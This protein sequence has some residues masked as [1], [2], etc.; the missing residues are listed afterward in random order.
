MINDPPKKSGFQ[1]KYGFDAFNSLPTI[2]TNPDPVQTGVLGSE[3]VGESEEDK[4]FWRDWNIKNPGEQ[5][6]LAWEAGTKELKG[7]VKNMIADVAPL[8]M[9]AASPGTIPEIYQYED[10]ILGLQESAAKDFETAPEGAGLLYETVRMMPQ[11]VGTMAALT[12]TPFTGGT[13]MAALPGILGMAN[14]GMLS[15]SVYGR[16]LYDYDQY[17]AEKGLETNQFT[18][19][20][21][22]A[23]S[24]AME[25]IAEKLRLDFMLPKGMA[26]RMASQLFKSDPSLADDVMRKWAKNDPKVYQ[27]FMGLGKTTLANMGQ[28]GAEE[29]LTEVGQSIAQNVYLLGEDRLGAMDIVI[30]AGEAAKGG[31]MMGGMLGPASYSS[32]QLYHKMRKN[33][34]GATIIE[35]EDGSV[36]EYL[37]VD[38]KDPNMAT[39]MDNRLNMTSI[40]KDHI[41]DHRTMTDQELSEYLNVYKDSQE[42]LPQLEDQMRR[43]T[44][45]QHLNSVGQSIVNTEDGTPQVKVGKK[46][47]GGYV[48]IKSQW[49]EMPGQTKM[50]VVDPETMELDMMDASQIGEIRTQSYDSWLEVQTDQ[51]VGVQDQQRSAQMEQAVV[52]EQIK[53]EAGIPEFKEGEK[54][55]YQD[56]EWIVDEVDTDGT[57]NV[58]ANEED[59]TPGETIP[60]SP[61]M[62][63]EVNRYTPEAPI[64]ETGEQQG[65]QK[66]KI[67]ND[68]KNDYPVVD[69]KIQ[70]PF[71]TEKA[72]NSLVSKLKNEYPGLNFT[73]DIMDDGDPFTKNEYTITV[74]PINITNG[75]ETTPETSQGVAPSQT[76][77][78]ELKTTEPRYFKD[79]EDVTKGYIQGRILAAKSDGDLHGLSWE[80]DPELDAMRKEKFPEAVPTYT[81][82]GQEIEQDVARGI[83]DGAT[84][85]TDL[86]QLVVKNDDAT[87]QTYLDKISE[88]QPETEE[89]PGVEQEEVS[90]PIDQSQED[91]ISEAEGLTQEPAAEETTQIESTPVQETEVEATPAKPVTETEQKLAAAEAEVD[92]NP[93]EAKIEAGNYKKGHVSIQ[94]LDITIENPKGSTRSGTDQDGKKWSQIINNTYGYF[95]RSM[96][97]DGDQIDVFLGENIESDKVFVVDQVD[98]KTGAF[99]EHKTM[100]G[101]DSVEEA[102]E[103]YLSNYEEGWQGLGAITEMSMVEFKKWVDSGTR[104]RKPVSEMKT[105]KTETPVID[106]E[107]AHNRLIELVR[108]YNKIPKSHTVKRSGAIQTINNLT[109][110]LGYSITR[111]DKG[112]LVPLNENSKQIR[113][114]SDQVDYISLVEIEDEAFTSFAHDFLVNETILHNLDVPIYG[115]ALFKAAKDAISGRKNAE[116]DLLIRNIQEMY[117]SDSFNYRAGEET[118]AFNVTVTEVNDL[119]AEP[120]LIKF[121]EENGALDITN[122]DKALDAGLVTQ[123]EYETVKKQFED[124]LNQ[125]E[126]IERESDTELGVTEDGDRVQD[127]QGQESQEIDNESTQAL[128]SEIA[129]LKESLSETRKARESKKKEL[130]KR[131]HQQQSMFAGEKLARMDQN[132][133]EVK[134]D[135]SRENIDKILGEFDNT[136]AGIENQ[137]EQKEKQLAT[138]KKESAGQL[139]LE[140]TKKTEK[141]EDFGEKIGGARKD[142][143][144]QSLA[145]LNK[146]TDDDLISLP[147]VKAIPVPDYKELVASG[148]MNKKEVALLHYYRTN[149]SR[150][151]AET[152]QNYKKARWLK[153]ANLY[154]QVYAWMLDKKGFEETHGKAFVDLMDERISFHAAKEIKEFTKML[155]ALGFPETFDGNLKKFKIMKFDSREDFTIINGRKI[156]ADFKTYD[157]A[158]AALKH[159]LEETGNQRSR[160]TFDA[161][162]L[163]GKKG[164]MVG[165]KVG[166][167][168]FITLAGPF[169]TGKEAFNYIKDNQETL[170]QQLAEEKVIPAERPDVAEE[171]S[172]KDHRN[173]KD[174][175]PDMF[176]EAF[177]FRGVEFGN[178]VENAKRQGD[179]NLAYDALMDLAEITNI[180]SRA[181]SLGGELGLA[182]GA[183]GKGGKDRSSAHYEPDKIVINLT[184]VWGAGSLAHEW[185]HAIDNY[186]SRQRDKKHDY[187]TEK[188]RSLL[189]KKDGEWV[190]DVSVRPEV[191]GV[192]YD[193][194]K[195]IKDSGMVERG[196]ELDRRKTKDYWSQMREMSA[197]S[198]ES[199][200][201]DKLDE[202]GIKNDY[203]V[204]FKDMVDYIVQTG[205]AE[206]VYP[207]PTKG[208]QPTINKSFENLFDVIE[209]V[210]DEAG[211][212]VLFKVE[213]QAGSSQEG[214]FPGTDVRDVA[215]QLSKQFNTPI[216]VVITRQELPPHIQ[217]A[218]K[219]DTRIPGVYDVQNDKVYLIAR[220]VKSK[221]EAQQTVFHEIVGHKGLRELLGHEYDQMLTDVYNSM[222][223]G[224]ISTM[225]RVYGT[226]DQLEIADEYIARIAED[227]S[228]P[229]IIDKFVA[230]VR[231]LIR[232]VFK[233]NYTKKDIIDLLSKSREGLKKKARPQFAGEY[234]DVQFKAEEEGEK[235]D[236]PPINILQSKAQ[237]FRENWQ[238]RM[239]SVRNLQKQVEERGGKITD[240]SNAYERENA[241][242]QIVRE[243]I[244]RFDDKYELPLLKA[245]SEIEKSADM[246]FKEVNEY[247]KAKH[248]LERNLVMAKRNPKSN[249]T[250]WSGIETVDAAKTVRKYESRLTKDQINDFWKAVNNATLFSLDRA[251]ADGFISKDLHDKLTK[252]EDAYKFY[253][254]LRGWEP[255]E[256]DALIDYMETDV[257]RIMNPYRSAKGRTTMAD[258][259]LK[260]ITN[261]AHTAIIM[262]EKNRVKQYA[263]ALVRNNKGMN[264]LFSFKK[265]YYVWDGTY[266]ENGKKNHN[267]TV[268]KPPQELFDEGKVEIKFNSDYMIRRPVSHAK[269]HEVDMWQ[270]GEKYVLILPADVANALNKTPSPIEEMTRNAMRSKWTAWAPMFTRW[271]ASEFTSRNPAFIPINQMRDVGYAMMAHAIKGERG[272]AGKFIMNMGKARSAIIRDLKGKLDHNSEV[273]KMYQDFVRLG[274]PT[275]WIHLRDVEQLEKDIQKKLKRLEGGKPGAKQVR[276]LYLKAGELLEHWAIRSENLSRF[277]TYITAIQNGKGS[278][279]AVQAAKDIT[280]NFNR[281]GRNT[282][283]AGAL[284]VFFN[285]GVQ[286]GHNFLKLG[287]DNPGKF[288]GVGAGFMALG[289][290]TA[291]FNHLWAGDDDD[292]TMNDYQELNDYHKFNSLVIPV[293]GK[294][295][296]VNIPLPFGFRA[297]N[298]L[299]VLA[300]QSL[301]SKEKDIGEAVKDGLSNI[302]T[303]LSPVNPIEFIN[304]D[305][306]LTA[307]PIIPTIGVPIFDIAT[308]EDFAGNTITRTPFTTAQEGYLADSGLGKK[309]VN[310]QLK[311][312]T[313]ELFKLGGGHVAEDDDKRNK[314][315]IDDDG[316]SK[317]VSEIFDWNPSKIEHMFEYLFAGRG[318][319]WNNTL[320]TSTGILEGARDVI[321]GDKGI[322]KILSNVNPNTVPV[323]RRLY[324]QSWQN[325][326]Y[327]RYYDLL[328]YMDEY[329]AAL[330]TESRKTGIDNEDLIDPYHRFVKDEIKY[331]N[332]D[333][334]YIDDQLD[335]LDPDKNEKLKKQRELY[336]RNFNDMIMRFQEKYDIDMK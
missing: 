36:Y 82:N 156:I 223:E 33:R 193:V 153:E 304:E 134:Q 191:V 188:P 31:A 76:G 293:P 149:M 300:Y 61:E 123:D 283:L 29:F 77:E 302:G 98:T 162:S 271:I 327:T 190:D 10:W 240:F 215:E 104:K 305:G 22:A 309:H 179:L 7:G 232:K 243:A 40:H 116:S 206:D 288:I 245:I 252:G 315:Y 210:N 118:G 55:T 220:E 336:I 235:K 147:L 250:N 221:E 109:G 155:E 71:T 287:K 253:V 269:E 70:Q 282:S 266:D 174:V 12:T 230:K 207:Y 239:L 52:E 24:A 120:K 128:E 19:R 102:R 35:T 83:I 50:I 47:N 324:V 323:F 227:N 69:G 242:H 258:D 177:G 312:L 64:T 44:T 295:R 79:E 92:Q 159:I 39:V 16:S 56:R 329:E 46:R 138:A 222:S 303:A 260:Y 310:K 241:S 237:K 135:G 209:T 84:E 297:F 205:A 60:I 274:G 6:K 211:N 13:S 257:G 262:G 58:Y 277:A 133:F 114:I 307:R 268:I 187:L 182:F 27:K 154:K 236:G 217:R 72:A 238:D 298:A 73:V 106:K 101:F 200:V 51:M 325:S 117:D 63:S 45:K 178:W 87:G 42:N 270:G 301:V 160:V 86:E 152:A 263:S 5:A 68:G 285:A 11:M 89:A 127:T 290:L 143:W 334:K 326:V 180:P 15:S 313:D 196:T 170:E 244:E 20:G 137:I 275:G 94:G 173:G 130:S 93:S 164:V 228:N 1:E 291:L 181:I 198:F 2:N 148:K 144:A 67:L 261:M 189:V 3:F 112:K 66:E 65:Q 204:S 203:L 43:N 279:Q 111:N 281:K 292:D 23:A 233:I 99:D 121:V 306:T 316:K 216:E 125:R 320:K 9:S 333:L 273:G 126:Q 264:D 248:A 319:F 267:E 34:N 41:K 107:K 183:R 192:F 197:R 185:W 165:K 88:L 234:L 199:Y 136:I 184:K 186:F 172:G 150:K 53:D 286:G 166:P 21:V 321:E 278:K 175:T 14:I 100:V 272:D 247:M 91:A 25:F 30:N 335:L 168:K 294:D 37:G 75:E 330:N 85:A 331:L 296:F 32:N 81:Y 314:Y 249:K 194:A 146:L 131:L 140:P 169:E 289:F 225:S 97:K 255:S 212:T 280:V 163:S 95:K 141:I 48:F 167:R 157:E 176:Q 201:K 308:N 38:S 202:Q 171:R 251:M 311:W 129:T 224:D 59:G 105:L 214:A 4:Q 318:R 231:R 110:Q 208:E 119:I 284:F 256:T 26:G 322:E 328:N 74:E 246:N 161:W 254:P 218:I 195:A 145:S 103:A 317:H 124:E 57:L 139:E 158:I 226:T 8:V 28:E 142:Q 265:V 96:G 18:R 219:D 151:P 54:I 132:L 78:D 49:E 259:P 108:A 90:A 229:S 115:K 213:E 299:G 80:N 122:I 276:D 62:L 332:K 113:T 17:V